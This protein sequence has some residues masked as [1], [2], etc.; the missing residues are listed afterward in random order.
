M[1]P[2]ITEV[3]PN[4]LNTIIDGTTIIGSIQAK[5]DVRFDG[6]L[7]GD[8]NIIGK[9]VVGNTGKVKGQV[10][11]K[12]SEILGKV[13]GK[14]V[15]EELLTLKESAHIYGDIISNKL[16]VEPGAVF[17]GT[18]NMTGGEK[19]NVNVNI[20]REKIRELEEVAQ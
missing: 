7:E 5:G 17:T 12:N 16:A 10:K 19:P 9:L 8:I 13:E 18:C 3:S 11:C 2:K 4:A 6:V 14:I 15:V 20:Q 1:K